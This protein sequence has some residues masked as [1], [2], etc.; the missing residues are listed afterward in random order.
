MFGCVAPELIFI[1]I[2]VYSKIIIYFCELNI[3]IIRMNS[4]Q[5]VES[6]L[7]FNL[8]NDSRT[9]YRLN[10]I[11]LML[12]ESNF[13]SLNKRLNYFVRTGKL[14]NP[15]KGIYAKPIYNVEEL[16]CRIFMPSYISLEYVLQ[17]S[18]VVFQYSSQISS[19]SYLSRSVDIDDKTF[20]FRKIRSAILVDTTGLI[21]QTNG[22]NIATPERALLDTLYLN[23]DTYFD[24]LNSINKELLYKLVPLYN[25]KKLTERINQLLPL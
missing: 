20:V 25:S 3:R 12:G 11:A 13:V 8:Y 15:R 7:I 4:S 6:D 5:K 19:V 22:V 18:G 2:F 14:Q 9:V 16:A 1:N 23:G 21:R 17:Q 24:N 10:D